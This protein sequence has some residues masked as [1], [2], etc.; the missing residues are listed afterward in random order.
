MRKS[1][2]YFPN[3]EVLSLE[4]KQKIDNSTKKH[5]LG[6]NF[7][8][9]TQNNFGLVIPIQ[10]SSIFTAMDFFLCSVMMFNISDLSNLEPGYFIIK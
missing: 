4:N 5:L 10:N 8:T 2:C 6:H 3:T 1:H 9:L 7:L